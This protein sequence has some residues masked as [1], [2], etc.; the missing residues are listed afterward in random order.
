M[1]PG[2]HGHEASSDAFPDDCFT[3]TVATKL[4]AASQ[5]LRRSLGYAAILA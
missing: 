5:L 1:A 2:H 3:R 4:Q